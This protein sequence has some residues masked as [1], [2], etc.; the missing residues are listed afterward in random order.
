[1][2]NS[3]KS[4]RRCEYFLHYWNDQIQQSEQSVPSHNS[5]VNIQ[6]GH[7]HAFA[8]RQALIT[9]L[10][11]EFGESQPHLLPQLLE[12]TPTYC[13]SVTKRPPES[14][15]GNFWRKAHGDKT[16]DFA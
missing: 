13:E 15:R 9:F 10:A 6:S 8:T 5:L 16:P 11:T 2:Q 12:Q 4:S 3:A 14:A 1:M 7:H